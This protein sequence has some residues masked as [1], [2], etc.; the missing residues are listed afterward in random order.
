MRMRMKMRIRM[1][2]RIW[3]RLRMMRCRMGKNVDR[4]GCRH[5]QRR[6]NR[7]EADSDGGD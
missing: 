2:M 6:I 7:A 4:E 5:R 1:T 3:M